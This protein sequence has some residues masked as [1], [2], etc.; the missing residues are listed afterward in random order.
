MCFVKTVDSKSQILSILVSC[1]VV[2]LLLL[3]WQN[4]LGKKQ[5]KKERVCLPPSSIYH[6]R[7]IKAARR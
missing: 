6:D 2:L 3:L 1:L 4:I 5:H 7:K